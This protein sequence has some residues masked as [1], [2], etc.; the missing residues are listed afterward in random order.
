[1]KLFFRDAANA[2]GAKAISLNLAGEQ[3]VVLT[4]DIIKLTFTCDSATGDVGGTKGASVAISVSKDGV[5]LNLHNKLSGSTWTDDSGNGYN[6]TLSGDF[7][8]TD[9]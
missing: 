9:E 5:I 4:R 1:M 8:I 2:D 7:E 6:M 3:T